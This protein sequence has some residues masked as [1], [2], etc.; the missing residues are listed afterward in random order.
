MSRRLLKVLDTIAGLGP[1]TQILVAGFAVL[2]SLAISL[3][4]LLR[5]PAVFND[6][7]G[8]ADPAWALA[9]Q[10]ILGSQLYV[11][12]VPG[13]EAHTYWYVPL[14]FV[15]LAAVF[16]VFGFGVLQGRLLSVLALLGAAGAI[17]PFSGRATSVNR[18]KGSPQH[19]RSFNSLVASSSR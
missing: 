19:E 15:Q 4:L 11:G 14:Y 16:K 6:E 1:Q 7:T 18:S 9:D 17:D 5:L 3:P 10:G 8:F 2:A 12:Q 13:I